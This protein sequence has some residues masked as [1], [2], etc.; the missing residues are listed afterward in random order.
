[1]RM[2]VEIGTG[3]EIGIGIASRLVPVNVALATLTTLASRQTVKHFSNL[4]LAYREHN[5]EIREL[6]TENGQQRTVRTEPKV[7][8]HS[9]MG[10]IQIH[11]STHFYAAARM[12]H[13]DSDSDSQSASDSSSN[14]L[15]S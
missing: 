12:P 14:Q 15:T 8:K 9:C 1:M 3:S 10:T 2:G 7:K 13:S 4:Q 6:R 11:N 5:S